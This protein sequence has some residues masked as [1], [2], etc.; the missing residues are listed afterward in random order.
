MVKKYYPRDLMNEIEPF[1][2]RAEYI[3]VVGPRQAGKTTLMNI[4][5]EYLHD[6][7][8][9][10]EDLV[11]LITFEDRRLLAEFES[12]PLQFINSYL[13]ERRD[14]KKFYL[15]LDEYQYVN[16]GGQKLKFVY[17][18]I[19]NLKIIITGSSSM[20][21]K[22]NIGKF[23]VG[24][25]VNFNLY[26]FNF[27]EFLRVRNERLGKIYREKNPLII[28][29]LYEG[30][31]PKEKRG[32]DVFAS[33]MKVE[34]EE[35]CLWGGYPEVIISNSNNVRKKLLYE[36]YN[37]YILKDIKT[38]LE[39]ATERNLYLLS[40]Y[41]ATQI[42]NITV[43]KNLSAESGL[44]HREL[45]QH[46]NILSETY[47][48]KEVKP[49][50]KNPQKELKKNPKIYFLDLGFRNSL[51][52][53]FNDL[54]RRT[55]SGAIVENTVFIRLNQLNGGINNLNFWR[56][57]TGTEVDFIFRIKNEILPVEVKYSEFKE[58]KI[59]RGLISFINSFG[60][61]RTIVLTKNFWG[62]TEYKNTKVLFAPVYYL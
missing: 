54:N 32:K 60:P 44:G 9:V 16:D 31:K 4:L 5:M 36:I 23:M 6:K 49:F 1:L 18:T 30:K 51:L 42:G 45:K 38:L 47:I 34:F 53:N 3:A 11:K 61:K 15:M 56:T 29:W 12:A 26:P 35:Y 62:L 19:D 17:D 46:L 59:P 8:G 10:S 14:F 55:A 25:M 41:L 40:Q 21:I 2:G 39:L 52:N 37:N 48:C 13:P 58:E 50:F 20:D 24:R 27:G 43:Y 57:K 33:E 22:G 28:K 7:F